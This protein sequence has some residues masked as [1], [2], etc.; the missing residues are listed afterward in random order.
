MIEFIQMAT[1]DLSMPEASARSA[2][3]GLLRLIQEQVGRDTAEQLMQRLPGSQDLLGDA[4]GATNG[5]GF[6]GLASKI[7][8]MFGGSLGIVE[9]AIGILSKAGL[10][11]DKIGPFASLFVEFLRSKAGAG[12]VDRV[13][14]RLPELKEIAT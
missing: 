14:D 9:G 2:T 7:G 10:S 13:L 4:S 1:R 5:G 3:R 11:P 6:G 8:S 12:A